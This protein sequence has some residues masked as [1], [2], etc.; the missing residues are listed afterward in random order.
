MLYFMLLNIAA[1]KNYAIFALYYRKTIDK[2]KIRI[3]YNILIYFV[4]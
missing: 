4:L 3:I 1:N 2:E